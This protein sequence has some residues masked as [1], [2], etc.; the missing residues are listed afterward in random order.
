[1]AS[2]RI[3]SSRIKSP[4]TPQMEFVAQFPNGVDSVSVESPCH[5]LY[6]ML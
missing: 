1:M 4:N 5:E 6:E 2:D 3:G